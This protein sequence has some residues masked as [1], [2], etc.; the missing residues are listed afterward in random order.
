MLKL[1]I[2]RTHIQ[3]ANESTQKPT[4]TPRAMNTL[5][6]PVYKPRATGRVQNRKPILK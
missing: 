2:S 1:R 3:I 5:H 4:Q 6:L